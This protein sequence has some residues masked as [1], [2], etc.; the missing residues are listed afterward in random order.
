MDTRALCC[1]I[2]SMEPS[3]RVLEK[4]LQMGNVSF[5]NYRNN[6]SIPRH[7]LTVSCAYLSLF[8]QDGGV[9]SGTC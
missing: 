2:V 8:M 9:C 1:R 4:A 6:I 7:A 3:K 5:K